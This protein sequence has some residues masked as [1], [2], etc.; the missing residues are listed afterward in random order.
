MLDFSHF[1]AGPYASLV[2]ADLGADIIKVEDPDHPDEA[3]R[4]GPC[5]DGDDSVY[6]RSLNWGKR[7]VGIRLGVPEGH[8]I[9]LELVGTTD[10]VLDNYRPGVMAKLGLGHDELSSVNERVVTVS[11]SGFGETGPYA[12]LPGYDYTIQA[13]AG[14]MSLTG[15]PG[16]PPG[17]AGIS[18]VDHAGGLAAALGVVAA[19]LERAR[20]GRGRHIDAALFDVQISMLSYL[21]AWQ[22][23]S[24]FVP[25]RTPNASHPSIVPAQ[26]FQ[27][28]DGHVSVFVGND[29]MWNRLVAAL[30]DES[31]RDPAWSTGAGRYEHRAEV[32][33]CLER[34]FGGRAV[35]ESVARLRAA[36]VPCAPINSVAEA[37]ADPHVTAR[38]LIATLDGPGSQRYRSVRGPLP[39]LAN[40]PSDGASQLGQDTAA[41]LAELGYSPDLVS[42]LAERRVVILPQTIVQT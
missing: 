6:F 23:H 30:E 7:S 2:L 5:F 24:G 39:G 25:G 14:V 40:P 42:E 37:L 11:L 17:K 4:V 35:A 15:D 27:A 41:V 31:L 8:R 22:L 36:G 28:A 38:G 21:A 16:T 13:L 34:I 3:R 9:V 10:V 29:Q 18:Y 19:L 26:T 32:V 33:S 20:T 12:S 1:L